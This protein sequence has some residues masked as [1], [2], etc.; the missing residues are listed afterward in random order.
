MLNTWTQTVGSSGLQLFWLFLGT[1]IQKPRSCGAMSIKN[2]K[3]T[4][5]T[6]NNAKYKI[7]EKCP[8]FPD[9]FLSKFEGGCF[10]SSTLVGAGLP[11]WGTVLVSV[12]AAILIVIVVGAVIYW[13]VHHHKRKNVSR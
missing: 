10:H 12:G 6:L 8:Q 13:S 1:C 5:W 3:V 7:N 2:L 9:S 11:D 4:I